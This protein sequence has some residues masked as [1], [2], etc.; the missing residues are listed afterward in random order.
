MNDHTPDPAAVPE[1]RLDVGGAVIA[2]RCPQAGLAEGL[3]AWF[4][5]ASSPRPAAV[6]LAVE[7][8]AHDDAPSYP[9]SLLTSKRL[10]PPGAGEAAAPGVPP[11][12]QPFDISDGLI[13][14]WYDAATGTGAVRVKA[15]LLAGRHTRIFEQVLYQAHRS[16]VRKLE[17]TA[18]LV[19]SSAV[20]AGGRGFLFVGPSGAGKST[21]AGLSAAHHVLGD[22]MNLLLP[23][24]GGGW[25]VAGTPFNGLFRAKR[26]GRAP[27]AAVLLLEHGPVPALCDAM[28]AEAVAAL[29]GEIVP[30]VG[31]DQAP[32]PGT[33]PAMVGAAHEV[34]AQTPLKV[35]RF[36]PDPGFW[37]VLLSAFGPDRMTPDAAPEE[38]R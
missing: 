33:L 26:P 14:G 3:A 9:R 12:A 27:L 30:P 11:S 17:L 5:V 4:G 35:L 20:I 13:R 18:W 38:R 23:R 22:E 15:A 25:D 24:P 28:P 8:V 34:A 2:L 10:L 31:L 37:P 29:A 16:A 32:G 7:V 36:A 1:Y 6:T 19:H 21:V